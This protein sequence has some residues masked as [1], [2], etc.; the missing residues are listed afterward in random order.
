MLMAI[1]M[2]W[3]RWRDMC[4]A[5]LFSLDIFLSEASSFLHLL[6]QYGGGASSCTVR[7]RD[8][9]SVYSATMRGVLMHLFHPRDGEEVF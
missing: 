1:S 6:A 2:L 3:V 5:G 7:V 4:C 8:T 9:M